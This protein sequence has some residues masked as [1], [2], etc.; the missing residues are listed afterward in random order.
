MS[1]DPSP[2]FAGSTDFAEPGSL[3]VED[4]RFALVPD[5]VIGAELSNA[6]F[7]V[8]SLRLR[9]GNTSECA[10]TSLA[11][12]PDRRPGRPPR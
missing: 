4:Q 1:T 5:W 9:L 10:T 7:R 3:L 11:R 12:L 8:Y 6:A 2:A